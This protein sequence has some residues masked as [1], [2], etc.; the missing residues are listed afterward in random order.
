MIA[1]ATGF[2]KII[3]QVWDKLGKPASIL[4]KDAEINVLTENFEC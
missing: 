2:P 3:R 4:E 1:T